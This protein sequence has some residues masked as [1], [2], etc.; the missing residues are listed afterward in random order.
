MGGEFSKLFFLWFAFAGP[1]FEMP[2]AAWRKRSLE[3]E[4]FTVY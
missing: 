4:V 3:E 1:Q 2:A